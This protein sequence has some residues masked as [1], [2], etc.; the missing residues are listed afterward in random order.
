MTKIINDEFSNLPI[1]REQKY[2][3]RH[4]ERIKEYYL[5]HPEQIKEYSRKYYL[6]NSEKY[7]ENYRKF[8]LE[9]PNYNKEYRLKHP[10]QKRQQYKKYRLVHSEQR[11]EYFKKYHLT[12]PEIK[13]AEQFAQH[14][15]PLN[16]FC[17]FGNCDATENLERAHL[18]YINYKNPD[19]VITMCRSHHSILDYHYRKFD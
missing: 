11:K 7:R 14:H 19:S 5:N 2:K 3:L 6:N 15:F 16:K 9:H 18:D 8:R 1:T 4:P 17:M 12:H 13:R 10:E